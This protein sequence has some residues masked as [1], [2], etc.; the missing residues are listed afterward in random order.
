MK[1]TLFKD[2]I[3]LNYFEDNQLKSIAK[4]ILK[5]QKDLNKGVS[6]SNENGFQTQDIN[7]NYLKQKIL[8][9]TSMVI[10][11][12]FCLKQNLQ[13]NLLNMWINENNQYSYNKIHLHSNSH[14][15]GV[16]YIDCPPNTGNIYFYRPDYTAS[17]TG[18]FNFFD[19][20]SEFNPTKNIK[21]YTNQFLLF[22]STMVHGV[23]QNINKRS[24]I[25]LSFNVNL[26]FKIKD[27]YERSTNNTSAS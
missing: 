8:E 22:P 15:S 19:N 18:L 11:N 20:M 27:I 12:D 21:N 14:L 16:Y 4:K 23:S 10:S 13:I 25:S 26:N 1:Q 17:I 9:W 3:F 24:R 5:E 7:N 6:K 2:S